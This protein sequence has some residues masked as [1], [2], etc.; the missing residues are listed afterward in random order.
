MLYE[1]I[2]ETYQCFNLGAM[3]IS[4]P[5]FYSSSHSGFDCAGEL[6][7]TWVFLRSAL[8]SLLRDRQC[9]QLRLRVEGSRETALQSRCRSVMISRTLC[10]NSTKTMRTP[11]TAFG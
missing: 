2:R 10:H 1:V 9:R 11:S 4:H 6:W 7:Q 8:G 3:H 5:L